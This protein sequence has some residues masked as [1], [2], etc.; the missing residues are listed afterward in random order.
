M[1]LLSDRLKAVAEMITPGQTVAD[2][3]CDHAYLPIYLIRENISPKVI[4]CDINE[5]PVKRAKGNVDDVDLSDKIEVRQGDGLGALLP[6]EAR[7]I[8]LAGMGGKLMIKIL[9]EGAD[10][11]K[12]AFEIIMEPQSEVAALRHFLQDNK[13]H[14]ISE[15]MVSEE[16]KFYPLIKAVHGD[17]RWDR[18]IYFRYGKILL[19]EENPV[20]HEFL[21]FEKDYLSNLIKELSANEESPQA[22]VRIEEVKTDLA[23]NSDALALV[24]E[25]GLFEDNRVIE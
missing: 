6:Q 17:M 14:I 9:E 12:G 8:V 11:V 19:R 10:I 22:F 24:S 2:I 18:E 1:A 16:G 25:T 3:G 15:N 13:L 20:L 7:S 4:A 5:G 21:V 23:L